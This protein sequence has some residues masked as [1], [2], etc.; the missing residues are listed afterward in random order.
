MFCSVKTSL[1]I[2]LSAF[3]FWCL[4]FWFFKLFFGAV[5]DQFWS[6]PIKK[7]VNQGR[8]SQLSRN[9]QK[10]QILGQLGKIQSWFRL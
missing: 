6:N 5:R 9:G 7:T 10:L 2:C 4:S 1:R 8:G 3:L